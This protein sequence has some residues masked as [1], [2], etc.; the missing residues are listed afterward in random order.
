M[1]K[2][3]DRYLYVN[4]GFPPDK[5][6][7]DNDFYTDMYLLNWLDP[8][9]GKKEPFVQ[10]PES[11][12]F[13]NGKHFFRNAW[14][15]VYHLADDRI[16]VAFGL[17]PV[18]YVFDDKPPYPLLSSLPLDLPEYRYFKGAEEFSPNWTFFG[19]RFTSGMI[20]NIKKIDGY[21]LVAYFPGYNNEDTEMRFSDKSPEEAVAFNDRMKKKYPHRISVLDSAGRVINDFVPEGLEAYSMLVRDGEL[22]MLETPD[23]EVEQDYFRLFK[24]GLKID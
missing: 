24:V 12:I 21:F 17:E 3:R 23:E 5:D 19:L 20:L 4:Q 15:P 18:I 9:T 11:C 16:Y 6:Y 1:E 10:F 13:R 14:D 2:L 8:K 7:S 22:W